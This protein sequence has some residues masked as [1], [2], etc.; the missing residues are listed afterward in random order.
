MSES[1]SRAR[2]HLANER[3]WLAWLRTAVA[4]MALGLAIAGFANRAS[5]TSLLAGGLLVG[6]GAA[7]VAFGTIRYRQV[8]AEIEQDRFATG[9]HGRAAVWASSMLI[10]AILAALILLT[11]GR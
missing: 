10:V 5:V 4:V 9:S 3:T 7:G 6:V 11:A 2:D 8:N 1:P